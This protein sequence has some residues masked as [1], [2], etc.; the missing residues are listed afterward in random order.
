MGVFNYEGGEEPQFDFQE[1]KCLPTSHKIWK[2][3]KNLFNIIFL[4]LFNLIS[5]FENDAIWY[6]HSKI[7]IFS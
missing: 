7:L 5:E 6:Y 4:F 3:D 1:I 2:K